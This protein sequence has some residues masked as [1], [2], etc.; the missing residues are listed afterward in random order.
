MN[1][2]ALLPNAQKDVGLVLTKQVLSVLE[3]FCEKIYIPRPLA[4]QL[5]KGVLP[6]EGE[7]IPTD[8]ELLLIIGG[9]GSLLHAA[10]AAM[11]ADI[12]LLGINMGRLGYLTSLEP[13]EIEKLTC[14]ADG[15]YTEKS[16]MTLE[17]LH[18][19][20][21]GTLTSM[22]CA[23]NDAV[24]DGAG[25]LAD[26]RLFDKERFLDYRA[27]GLILSTPTGSTAYSL[28]AGGPVID[29]SMDAICV[30]PICPRSFF[31]RSILFREDAVLRV[32]Y[33][34]ER[35]EPLRVSID[36]CFDFS[37]LPSEEVWGV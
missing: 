26:L 12:P 24:V 34:G 23:L 6:Y 13:S 28:S 5:G 35:V 27:G 33:N 21:D 2:I 17:V 16:R 4:A 8:A 37:L 15:A 11:K 3:R 20:A 10:S 36:G 25:H 1:K 31:S 7:D 29:E 22:G 9:D 19:K 30:T 14:L 32:A 18:K